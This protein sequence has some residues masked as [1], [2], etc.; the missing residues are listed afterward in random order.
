MTGTVPFTRPSVAGAVCAVLAAGLVVAPSS[1]VGVA[2]TGQAPGA[3]GREATWV[4]GDKDAFGTARGLASKVWFTASRGKLNDVYYPRIDTPSVRDSQFVVTDGRSFTDREDSDARSRVR[5]VD[6]RSLTYRVVNTARSGKWR[7]T[8]TFVTDPSRSTVL[9]KVRFRSLTGRPYRLYLL[10]DPALDMTGDD[11]T[12]RTGPSGSLLS[13]DGGPVASAVRTRPA[14]TRASSGYLGVSDGWSDLRDDHVMD[15]TYAAAQPGNVVQT[16]RV[17]VNG[18][19]RRSVTVAIGFGATEDAALGTASASLAAGFASLRAA[20]ERGWDRYLD[21]TRE[22]PRSLRRWRAEWDVSRMVL[23]ASED[24]T[25][26]GGFVASPGKPWAW[27]NE[28]Q[29]LPVYHA[30]WSRDLW[31][32]ATGALAYGDRA[33]AHRMLD[34]LWQHQQRPDGSFPQNSRLDGTPVFGDL[35]M[36]E[37]AL[38]IVLAKRLGRTG[39]DDWER[40]K[41][42]ADYVVANGP[43]T[44]QE[45]W[46][47]IGGYSP[48]TIAAEI[49][50]LVCAASIARRNGD[51]ASAATYLSTA[52][53]WARDVA[54]WTATSNG[55]YRPRP[56]YLRVTTEGNPDEGDQI[57]ISDGGP[58]VDQRRVV[59]PSF[60]DL[61]RLGVKRAANRIVRRSLEVVD[62]QLGFRTPNGRFWH[63]A[64][65]DGY[66]ER[67]DGGQWAPSPEG[68]RRTLGRGW[69]LLSGE[70]GE[71]AVI[72]G[73]ERFARRMLA[74]M[75]GSGVAGTR[76]MPEQVWD[77][78]RPAGTGPRYRPGEATRSALPLAWTHAQFLR[79]AR[80]V[81]DGALVATPQVVA[82]RYGSEACRR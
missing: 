75:A 5:W 57:Q 53:A 11:D 66:G 82:C 79:L 3:P 64:S 14:M 12:G 15:W 50:G 42:S 48:N 54:S 71:Y 37:V 51:E 69:P 43:S 68:S 74:A 70:R 65:F 78:R 81:A 52:D 76:Y 67:R 29:D 10:H 72:A 80:A 21:R 34:Y 61:V 8:K 38:P 40:V 19:S 20:Y 39:P 46:E 24:K 17:P 6:R 30:V 59:D 18:T 23:A 77:H 7:I 56:Y 60:V 16:G 27:A 36:D 4:P 1:G 32:I 9:Q 35:Q 26:R 73:R 25:Y 45:R 28:L 55:P 41:R 44:P 2:A 49:A 47:N 63:R 58:L 13:A 22:V 62:E 33:A 31:Q